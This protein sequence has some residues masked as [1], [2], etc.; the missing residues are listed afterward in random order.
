[1]KLNTGD[2]SLFKKI[3]L[4][5]EETSTG[6]TIEF[7]DQHHG[8]DCLDLECKIVNSILE[9]DHLKMILNLDKLNSAQILTYCEDKEDQILYITEAKS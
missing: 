3:T 4:L 6:S 9:I 2:E 8:H 1:M 5:T 7:V